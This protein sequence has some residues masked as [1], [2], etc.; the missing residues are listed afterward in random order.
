VLEDYVKDL[1]QQI[2]QVVLHHQQ[3]LNIREIQI[4]Q[5]Q[6]T[7]LMMLGQEMQELLLDLSMQLELEQQH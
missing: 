7:I 6:Q 5:S 4:A 3:E 2:T 1:H